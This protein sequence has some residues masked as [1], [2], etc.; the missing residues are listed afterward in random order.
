MNQTQLYRSVARITGE[1]VD[2]IRQIGFTELGPN[3]PE[4]DEADRWL[5]RVQRSRSFRFGRRHKPLQVC[6]AS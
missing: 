2:L 1:P 3:L 6:A 5:R 4:C